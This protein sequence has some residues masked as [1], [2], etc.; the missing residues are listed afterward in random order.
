MGI[1][2]SLEGVLNFTVNEYNVSNASLENHASKMQR[3]LNYG[4]DICRA[5]FLY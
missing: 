5:Y 1:L 3:R 2:S 4:Y